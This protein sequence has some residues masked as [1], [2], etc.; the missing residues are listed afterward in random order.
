MLRDGLG[1]AEEDALQVVYLARVLHLDDDD[2]I[3][4]IARLDVHTVEL[5]V[6]TLLVALAFQYLDDAI[7]SPS[8]TVR[9]PSS[10]PKLAL[11]RSKR[12]TAQSNRIYLSFCTITSLF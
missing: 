1:N 2:F 10:T 3:L 7:G 8:N 6:F 9:K 11:L 5:I 4:T 12:F